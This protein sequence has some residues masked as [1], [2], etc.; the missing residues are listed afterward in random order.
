MSPARSSHANRIAS[1]IAPVR[2]TGNYGSETV[3]GNIAF[4]PRAWNAKLLD[5]EFERL[6][7]AASVTYR[8][9]RRGNRVSFIA[10]KQVPWHHY[11]RLSVEQSQL[12]VRSPYLDNE[13]V[14]LMYE[15]PPELILSRARSLRLIAE[16]N[17]DLSGIPTDRGV[18]FR[19][20]RIISEIR[21]RFQEFTAKSEYAYDYGMPQWLASVDHALSPLHIERLFLGRHKFYHFRIWYRD[22]L[23]KYLKEVLLD[24]RSLNRPYVNGAMLEEMVEAHVKG[25]RNYTAE[26]HRMLTTELIQRQL[27][28]QS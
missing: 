18:S 22:K 27:V 28:E 25:N 19:Q 2:L 5:P 6:V 7:S 14:S 4:G 11:S 8:D 16:G 10:F 13:L 23:S 20:T 26:I 9:E 21:H 15:A 1:R 17:A 3:R 24:P 12:T